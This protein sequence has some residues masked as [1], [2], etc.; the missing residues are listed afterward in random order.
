MAARA[1][2]GAVAASEAGSAG[3]LGSAGEAGASSQPDPRTPF[4]EWHATRVKAQCTKDVACG[5]WYSVASCVAYTLNVVAYDAYYGAADY[6]GAQ[7]DRYSLGSSTL[8]QTC[9]TDIAAEACDAGPNSP[10]SCGKVLVPLAPVAKGAS[11]LGNSPYLPTL[12]C[13]AGLECTRGTLCPVCV[14]EV[15]PADLNGTCAYQDDCKPG[16]VCRAA[17][18]NTYTCQKTLALGQPCGGVDDC[19]QGTCRDTCKHSCSTAK[20]ARTRYR[21][22][23]A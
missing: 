13:A 7:V 4:A 11:C 23:T 5:K 14:D 20:R 18:D 6:Y 10:L 9:L 16:L 1:D 21:A 22:C 12:P 8:Q 15:L 19:A 2:G 17:G 3:D